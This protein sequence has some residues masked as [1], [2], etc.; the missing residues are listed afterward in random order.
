MSTV[1]V[2]QAGWN[3]IRDGMARAQDAATRIASGAAAGE[4]A[5]LVDAVV[6]L[7]AAEQQVQASARVVEAGN[8]TLG[9][10]LDVLA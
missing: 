5:E 6:E 4:P 10:L 1:S 8:R 3:G 7:E 2:G 9:A